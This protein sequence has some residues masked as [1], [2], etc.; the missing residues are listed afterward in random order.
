MKVTV[1]LLWLGWLPFAMG[2]FILSDQ[3][4]RL[5]ILMAVPGAY[6]AVFLGAGVK[7][8]LWRCPRCGRVFPSWGLL[9]WRRW[10]ACSSCGVAFDEI[11]GRRNSAEEVPRRPYTGAKP[12]LP[13][14]E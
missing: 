9:P 12:P 14:K 13:P 3:F 4:P 6:L 2:C 10:K 5:H 8:N 1:L 7:L 11:C